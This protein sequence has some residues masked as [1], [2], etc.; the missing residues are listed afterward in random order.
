M[1]PDYKLIRLEQ[2]YRSTKI[3]V[4]AS[5]NII[6]HNK[7]QIKK[8]VWS[9]NEQGELISL[10]HASTDSEEGITTSQVPA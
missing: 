2:N 1:N 3:I 10:L 5:N 8:R 7:D 4:E 6:A 9:D